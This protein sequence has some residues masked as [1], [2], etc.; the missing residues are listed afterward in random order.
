MRQDG[1]V[2]PDG[3]V[4]PRPA[5]QSDSPQVVFTIEADCS[6]SLLISDLAALAERIGGTCPASRRSD[7]QVLS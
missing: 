7:V 4:F 3:Q 2:L 6:F 5:E 1:R